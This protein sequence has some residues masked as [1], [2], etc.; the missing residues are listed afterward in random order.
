MGS[1]LFHS[2]LLTAHE[3]VLFAAFIFNNLRAWFMGRASAS[4]SSTGFQTCCIADFQ[5]GSACPAE[6]SERGWV[7]LDQPHHTSSFLCST[8]LSPA[9]VGLRHG[10]ALSKCVLAL[11]V[12]GLLAFAP[13]AWCAYEDKPDTNPNIVSE[14]VLALEVP[15]AQTI[16]G[17]YPYYGRVPDEMLPFRN[18]KPFYQYWLTR[19]PFRG[20]GRDY[21]DPPDLKVLRVGLL[22]PPPY[23]PEALRGEMSK[24]GVVLALDEAN[25]AR[26]PGE[27]PFEVIEKADSPQWG[28]AANIAV[29]FA[30]TNVLAFL[31]TI[32]GDAAHVAL[33]VALKI[34]TFMVNCSDPDPTLT[35]TQIPWLIRNFPD[36]RQMGYRLAQLIVQERRLTNIVVFRANNRPGRIGVRPFVHA[37]R[38]MGHPIK[39]EINFKEGDRAFDPQVAVIKQAQPDAVVFWGNAAETG[40]AA[41]QLRA[42]G[43]KAAFFGFDRLVDPEFVKLAGPAAEGVT[44]AFFFDP[45]KTDPAWTGFVERFQ[46]RYGMKPDIYAGYAYDGAQMLIA[47]IKKVGPNRYR[48]RDEMSGLDEYTGVTGHMRFDARWD[49]IAPIVVAEYKEGRWHFAPAPQTSPART[50]A[51]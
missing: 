32:D 14:P 3:P 38:R 19:L 51:K 12:T 35:E 30:D 43:V 16:E 17:D 1:S 4:R 37:V 48:I 8:P 26:A 39:Q 44:A 20:P 27:L 15:A 24:R 18:V 49:N 7:V 9:V 23:G 41:A 2:D 25:A 11:V 6:E 21:P 50:A 10:R 34:E 42:A 31:G 28:S 40:R 46:K 36:N 47:A 13:A 29:E 33:R 5:I 45:D 22:S